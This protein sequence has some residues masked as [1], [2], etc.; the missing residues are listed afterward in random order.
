LLSR[1]LQNSF[2]KFWYL[3]PALFAAG[4]ALASGGV[5]LK[6]DVCSIEVGFYEARFTAYQPQTSGNEEFCEDLPDKGESI[7]VLDYLHASMREVP[8]SFRIIRDT[9]GLGRFVQHDDI[10]ALEDIDILTVFYQPPIVKPGA[11][12]RIEHEFAEKGEYIGIV[13]AGH[14]TSDTIYSAVFPFTV[15]AFN[16]PYWT[17]AIVVGVLFVI[18]IRLAFAAKSGDR[19]Q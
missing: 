3:L 5:I 16:F 6:G 12:F 19:V 8:V 7:F 18:L 2:L 4:A 9:T 13:T 1:S 15:G 14:P 17:L 10:L 11:S